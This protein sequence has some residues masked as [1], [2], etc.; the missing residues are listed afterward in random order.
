MDALVEAIQ[1]VVIAEPETATQP[2]PVQ[3]DDGA[4]ETQLTNQINTLWS[5][6]SSLAQ[7]RPE[8][9]RRGTPVGAERR[10]SD[11]KC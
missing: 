1:D 5:D 10:W 2:D 3:P 7:R 4:V 11:Q 6:H 9:D 8:D